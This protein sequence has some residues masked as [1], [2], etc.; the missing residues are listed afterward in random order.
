MRAL[1]STFTLAGVIAYSGAV[2]SHRGTP[3]Y[4]FAA[5]PPTLFFHGT[6]DKLVPY[7]KIQI[8]CL[9]LFGSSD[10]VKRYAKERYPYYIRRYEGYGHAAEACYANTQ[11]VVDFFVDNY[12]VSREPMRIDERFWDSQL[13]ID[14][15]L[16]VSLW[17]MILK[18]K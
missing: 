14:P 16:D 11:D 6:A 12:G 3:K 5:P 17:Q 4:R 15:A 7:K 8:F 1:P 2:L 9:G 18:Y 10:L 13:K